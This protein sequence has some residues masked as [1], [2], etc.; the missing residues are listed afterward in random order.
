[1]VKGVII[2]RKDRRGKLV[3]WVERANFAKIRRLL[4]ISEQEMHHEV[5]LTVKNFHDLSRHPFLYSVPIIP[6]PLPSEVVEGEHFV[7]ADLLKLILD[8][9]SPA[10]EAK[11][12]ATGRELVISTQFAQPSSTSEDSDPAPQAPKQVEGGG[13]LEHP[14]LA[15]KGFRFVPRMLK[16]KKGRRQKAVGAGAEDFILWVPLIFLHSPDKEEEE[17]EEDDMSGLVHNFAARKRKRDAM[18]EQ[19]VDATLEVAGGVTPH[20]SGVSLTTVKLRKPV[21]VM[22]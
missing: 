21:C 1:M 2:A 4:E 16:K 11:S 22:L 12:E 7:A 20:F 15:I 6:R 17:E 14:L 13:R 10:K 9:S 5:L 8:G 3:H 18:L 19:T